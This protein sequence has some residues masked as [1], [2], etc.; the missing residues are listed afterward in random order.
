MSDGVTRWFEDRAI[1]H[2]LPWRFRLLALYCRVMRNA[3]TGVIRGGS[4]LHRMLARA[5]RLLRLSD[6]A[7][8]RIGAAVVHLDLLDARIWWVL[9]EV[10]GGGAEHDV[11]RR[12]IAA[13][14]TFVDVGANHGGYAV[15]ASAL[16]GAGGRV[17]AIEPQ[18]R[19]ARLVEQS[20]A[21][22][23][24]SPYEVLPVACGD[25]EQLVDLF[26]PPTGSGSASVFAEY[27]AGP[28]VRTQVRQVRLD[29][30]VDW[31]SFPGQVFVKLDVEG[32]ELAFLQGAAEMIRTH[33]PV[34]L[35]EINPDSAGAGGYG[36]DD[37][38]RLLSEL[39]YD[40]GVELDCLSEVVPLAKLHHAP[41][42]NVV[43]L[44]ALNESWSRG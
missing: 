10:R 44:H 22:T 42:R 6:A 12:C 41:Q 35:F 40:R 24:A 27:Q 15:F 16:T 26:I 43:A 3:A 11:L 2:Q 9:D 23:G 1:V 18:P 13:G 38:L 37:L 17:V 29:D 25:R 8:V 36:V 39:G 21:A 14:D 31:R 32:S 19:L 28:H 20:L 5:T 33:R 4:F 7:P 34:I 30:A